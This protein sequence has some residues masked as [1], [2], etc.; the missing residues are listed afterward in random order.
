VNVLSLDELRLVAAFVISVVVLVVLITRYSVSPFVSLLIASVALA[1]CSGVAWEQAWEQFLV[2]VGGILSS[3][4]MVIGLGAMTGVLLQRSGGAEQ[5]AE[6]MV[7]WMGKDRLGWAM[8][9]VGLV[10]GVGVWFTVGLVLLVPI[11]VSLARVA[12]VSIVVPAMAMLAGLSAMH[13]LA[14]PHPGPLVA[15]NLLGADTGRTI[16]WSLLVGSLSAAISGPLFWS[17]WSKGIDWPTYE[18]PELDRIGDDQPMTRTGLRMSLLVIGLPIA[19]MLAA[20]VAEG[21]LGGD[22]GSR[23]ESAARFVAAIGTPTMAMLIGFLVAYWLL[24]LRSGFSRQ[25]ISKMT[26]ESLFPVANV[27]L[28]VAAG[29]GYSKVLIACGVGDALADLAR[30]VP[31]PQLVLGWIIAAAFRVAT[32]SA[33]TAITAAGGIVAVMIADDPNVHRELLVL[34]LGA[35][36]LTLS[37]VNDGGFWFVKELFSLTVQQTLKTW[38]VLETVLSIVALA[39]VL[40]LDFLV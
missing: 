16:L 27:L 11:T 23:Y 7:R 25:E 6:Q 37:H 34:A 1:I 24:G 38:T 28:V 31:V 26:E 19:L 10:V 2:G 12:R 22:G 36:S 8:L 35:G 32:G 5:I 21:M 13:G 4:A 3:T 17:W 29:A 20:S 18:Q 33:T 30:Q 15:I 9:I 39:V 40:F 14:P